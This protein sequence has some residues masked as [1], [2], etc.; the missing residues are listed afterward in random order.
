MK[1]KG[2]G[3]D[4]VSPMG[5]LSPSLSWV[6]LPAPIPF[7]PTALPRQHHP[8]WEH[9]PLVAV[10]RPSPS[11]WNVTALRKSGVPPQSPRFPSGSVALSLPCP[12]S[13]MMGSLRE[14]FQAGGCANVRVRMGYRGV[15]RE[16]G[17]QAGVACPSHSQ[18]IGYSPISGLIL[19][20][21]LLVSSLRG[22]IP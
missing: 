11:L 13:P 17:V 12:A 21:E 14:G 18:G 9:P 3:W 20:L 6:T 5:F 19:C 16:F 10:A 7:L 4:P 8:A 2:V 15:L 1:E 22:W